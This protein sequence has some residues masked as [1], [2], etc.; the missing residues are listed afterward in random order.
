MT[1]SAYLLSTIVLAAAAAFHLQDARSGMDSPHPAATSN[2]THSTF[3]KSPS[4][5]SSPP[6]Q[7]IGHGEVKSAQQ[8]QQWVF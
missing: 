8:P 4:F 3:Y 7:T 2:T 6:V 1:L 5:T